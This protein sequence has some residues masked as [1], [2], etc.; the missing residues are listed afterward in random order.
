[1]LREPNGIGIGPEN[2]LF[3]PDVQGNWLPSNKLINIR[4]GRFYGFKHEP[5]ETWDTQKEYPPAVYLP[6]GELAQAPGTPLLIPAGALPGDR[7]VGQMLLGDAVN[8]GIRR[9][10]LEKVNGE[11]Q[12]AAFAFTGGLE[13]GPNRMVWGP[14][15]YLYVGMCGQGAP[16]WAYKKDYGLQKIKPNGT[17]VFEMVSVRSRAGGL[18]IQYTHPVNA[19]AQ[20]AAAYNVRSWHYE[21][22]SDYGGPAIGTKTLGVGAVQVSPDKKTVF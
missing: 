10:F 1:G 17:D 5:A 18:E 9:I 6:Q 21:P 15:G 4:K 14:D 13:A 2:E 8:G 11:F 20:T 16:D 19:A 22:K 12:G 7:F 3:I